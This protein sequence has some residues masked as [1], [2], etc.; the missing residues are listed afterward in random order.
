[1]PSPKRGSTTTGTSERMAPGA[2]VLHSAFR[3][4][5]PLR[6]AQDYGGQAFRARHG[7]VPACRDEAGSDVHPFRRGGEG[8][9]ARSVAQ[10]ASALG[11]PGRP[12]HLRQ[13]HLQL[14]P[15][16]PR[17]VL[18]ADVE[19]DA[20][21]RVDEH[22]LPADGAGARCA[23]GGRRLVGRPLG[24]KMKCLCNLVRIRRLLRHDHAPQS[25][26]MCTYYY[27][28]RTGKFIHNFRRA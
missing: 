23:R 21:T 22:R 26:W 19:R 11:R 24:K 10:H 13:E 17:P 15:V 3:P 2:V 20:Q 6:Q 9:G 12:T 25:A 8:F 7:E 4:P 27:N 18:R 16:Q 28:V 1:M 14:P 5:S